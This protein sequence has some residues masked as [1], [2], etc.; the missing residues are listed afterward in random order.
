MRKPPPGPRSARHR[1][2]LANLAQ[3]DG[4]R[5]VWC[6]RPLSVDDPHAS[7][8]HLIPNK[9]SGSMRQVNLALSCF[10][11]NNERGDAPIDQWLRLITRIGDFEP[12]LP[13]IERALELTA[14]KGLPFSRHAGQQLKAVHSARNSQLLGRMMR[15]YPM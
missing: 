5:C 6:G 7:L 15:S 14:S 4:A 8:D 12:N 13:A 10:E 3:R 2:L 11:C 9:I 1:H